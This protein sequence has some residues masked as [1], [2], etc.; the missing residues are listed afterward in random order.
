MPRYHSFCSPSKSTC[1]CEPTKQIREKRYPR[2][3]SVHQVRAETQVTGTRPDG[4]AAKQLD[5]YLVGLWVRDPQVRPQSSILELRHLGVRCN[6]EKSGARQ[7]GAARQRE[8]RSSAA[9]SDRCSGRSHMQF[10][11]LRAALPL[12]GV[13]PAAGARRRGAPAQAILCDMCTMMN[14]RQ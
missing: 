5:P 9:P 3:H 6:N 14:H 11:Q 7:H 8:T 4:A 10:R 2:S 1:S 12:L 13:A